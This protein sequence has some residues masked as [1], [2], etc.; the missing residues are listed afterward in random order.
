MHKKGEQKILNDLTRKLESQGLLMKGYFVK[1]YTYDSVD[2]PDKIFHKIVNDAEINKYSIVGLNCCFHEEDI[3]EHFYG[4]IY[5][6]FKLN[7]ADKS[8]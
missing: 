8:P 1:P 2:G 6:T 3:P 7:T 5:V 4:E